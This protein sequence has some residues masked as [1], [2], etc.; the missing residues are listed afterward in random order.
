[1]PLCPTCIREHS[2][3]HAEASIKPQY[4]NINETL[5]D[6]EAAMKASLAQLEHD[7]KRNVTP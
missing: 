4:Y 1:M 6:V 5:D 2:Q 3:Y 7:K